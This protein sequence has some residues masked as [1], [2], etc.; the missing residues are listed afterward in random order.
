LSS[1]RKGK[2]GS[3]PLGGGKGKE[4]EITLAPLPVT[5]PE[6]RTK[7]RFACVQK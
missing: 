3:T 6:E 5:R 4:E 1:G 7:G 2:G